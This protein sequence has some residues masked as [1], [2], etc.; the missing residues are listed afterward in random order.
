MYVKTMTSQPMKARQRVMS[1]TMAKRVAMIAW[2]KGWNKEQL[3]TR[4]FQQGFG[5]KSLMKV[6]NSPIGLTW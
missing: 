3:M 1:D 6:W 4:L 5:R 2:G